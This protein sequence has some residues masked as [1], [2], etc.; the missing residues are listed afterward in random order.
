MAK[1]NEG[2]C[3]QKIGPVY[4][5]LLVNGDDKQPGCSK[6]FGQYYCVFKLL[7]LTCEIKYI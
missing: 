6:F 7:F 4:T 2:A 3:Y 5:C 1:S